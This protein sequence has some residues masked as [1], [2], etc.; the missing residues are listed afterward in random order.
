MDYFFYI[1]N[2]YNI[3]DGTTPYACNTDLLSPLHNIER[4]V[5]AWFDA[6]YMKLNQGKCH[7]LLT[8]ITPGVIWTRVHEER[9]WESTDEK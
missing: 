9:I 5:I 3:A 1:E 8:G 6:N 4:D 7:F 2:M